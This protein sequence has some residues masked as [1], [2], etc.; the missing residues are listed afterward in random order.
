MPGMDRAGHSAGDGQREIVGR[1]LAGER[2]AQEDLYAAHAGRVKAYLLRRGFAGPDA[3]DLTQDTFVRAFRS[4]GTFDPRRGSLRTWIGAIAR[5]VA[6]KRW[7]GRPAPQTLSLEFAEEMF[8]AEDNPGESPGAREEQAALGACIEELPAEL[9]RLIRLRYVEGRT[10]R[11]IS[12]ATEIPE[13][14]VRARL[15]EARQRLGRCLK[16]K[17]FDAE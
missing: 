7:G 17:G 5:N 6:R 14:T 13:A 4:L 16:A 1:C 8:P 10:T 9:G 12:A 11:G 15:V 3:D 2:S